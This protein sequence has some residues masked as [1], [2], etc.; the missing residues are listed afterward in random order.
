MRLAYDDEVIDTLAA[1]RADQ[2]F[3]KAILPRRVRRYRLVSDAHGTKSMFDNGSVTL[4]PIA[5]QVARRFTPGE[6]LS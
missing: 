4:I 3:G 2:P 1:D 6:C 5:D